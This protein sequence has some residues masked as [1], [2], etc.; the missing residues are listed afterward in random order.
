MASR[1]VCLADYERYADGNLSKAVREYFNGGA[2]YE[3]TYADNVA[4]FKRYV[5][6]LV[7]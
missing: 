3:Q 5:N 7:I 6:A 1:L 2:N 4:A